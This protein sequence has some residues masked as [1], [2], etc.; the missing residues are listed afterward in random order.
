MMVSSN[1]GVL[2]VLMVM[3]RIVNH[4]NWDVEKLY[5]YAQLALKIDQT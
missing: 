4:V 3:I 5:R 2:T 1:L